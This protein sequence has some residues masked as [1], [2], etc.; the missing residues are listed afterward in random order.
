MKVLF[1]LSGEDL[2]LAKDEI[3]S[4]VGKKGM[5]FGNFLIADVN[6]VKILSRLAFTHKYYQLLFT[7][8][9]R[10]FFRKF[11][12]FDWSKIYSKSF[13]LRFHDLK[14]SE[15]EMASYIWDKVKKPKVDLE[16]PSTLIE[17]YSF[18]GKI[19]C[20]KLLGRINGFDE[21]RNPNRP[22]PHPTTL[23][24]KL[25]RAMVNL[26][27]VKKGSVVDP[28][29]GTGGIL[30]EAGLM[31][32]KAVGSD[33]SAFMVKGAKQNLKFFKVKNFSVNVEDALNL[34]KI[35]YVVVDLPYGKNTKSVDRD[36][37]NKFLQVLREK[38]GKRAVVGFPD[39]VN[40][41]SLLKRNKFKILGEYDY[42]LH[43]SLSK[44]IVVIS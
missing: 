40:Y 7:C 9:N 39:F 4:L 35:S 13:C 42:F 1:V 34:G 2:K 23:H 12:A 32:L 43:K 36:F 24:P 19:F 6:D 38:L 33:I 28:M 15:R 18:K 20:G 8:S 17:C 16:N 27:G 31:G 5:S 44:K 21:R 3:Y 10:E 41:K 30:I 22:S 25:A 37:Y 26:L 14:F 11:S 29:C